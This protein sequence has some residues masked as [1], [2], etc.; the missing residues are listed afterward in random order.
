[1]LPLPL[2]KIYSTLKLANSVY[3]SH[4]KNRLD[5]AAINVRR[6]KRKAK[7]QAKKAGRS[8]GTKQTKK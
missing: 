6:P 5:A 2:S 8:K 1:L 4:I 7:P 3:A